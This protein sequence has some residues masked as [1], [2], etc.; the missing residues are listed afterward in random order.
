MLN[1]GLKSG[2][3]HAPFVE[4]HVVVGIIEVFKIS[5]QDQQVVTIVG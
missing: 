2:V 5:L 1:G 4:A 3:D